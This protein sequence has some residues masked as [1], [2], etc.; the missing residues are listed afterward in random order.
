MPTYATMYGAQMAYVMTH[1]TS[2]ATT[3]YP[4]VITHAVFVTR[5]V[6]QAV[7]WVSYGTGYM[8]LG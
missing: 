7:P 3:F 8:L 4:W 5:F 6:A 1:S 2:H